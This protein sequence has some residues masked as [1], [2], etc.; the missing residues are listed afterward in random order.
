MDEDERIS[1]ITSLAG[2]LS[3]SSLPTMSI[4]KLKENFSNNNDRAHPRSFSS[5]EFLIYDEDERVSAIAP[6][7]SAS[8]F[9]EAESLSIPSPS[10]MSILH[11]NARYP[12]QISDNTRNRQR[13]LESRLSSSLSVKKKKVRLHRGRR[14]GSPQ[15]Q[16]RARFDEKQVVSSTIYIPSRQ[17]YSEE[18]KRAMWT[19]SKELDENARRNRIEYSYDGWNLEGATEEDQMI[20]HPKAIRCQI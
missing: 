15:R 3:I 4:L 5:S 6:S 13:L 7:A 10:I 17:R 11:R 18:E 1:G 9:G 19:S 12:S 2:S 20:P 16:R 14:N 8:L